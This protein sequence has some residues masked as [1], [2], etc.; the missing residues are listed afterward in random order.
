MADIVKNETL[1]L[2]ANWCNAASVALV[3][4]GAFAPVVGFVYE[5]GPQVGNPAQIWSLAVICLCA[6]LGLHLIGQVVL[7]GLDGT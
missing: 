7:G 6:G 1:K 5:I 2:I 3:G 4:A